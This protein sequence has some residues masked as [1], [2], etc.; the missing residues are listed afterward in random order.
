MFIQN[1]E[2]KG[3]I[4]MGE[5]IIKGAMGIK[6]KVFFQGLHITHVIFALI[7]YNL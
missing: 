7:I 6:V 3:V 2:F 1:L 4:L 5:I